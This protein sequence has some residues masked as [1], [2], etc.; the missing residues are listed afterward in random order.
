MLYGVWTAEICPY[1]L[2]LDGNMGICLSCCIHY[3]KEQSICGESSTARPKKKKKMSTKQVQQS[4]LEQHPELLA[5]NCYIMSEEMNGKS[6]YCVC[7]QDREAPGGSAAP[8]GSTTITSEKYK[9][10]ILMCYSWLLDGLD[11]HPL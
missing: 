4:L 6:K 8:R 7:S 10:H 3:F 5:L 2:F 11:S 9:S 1:Q